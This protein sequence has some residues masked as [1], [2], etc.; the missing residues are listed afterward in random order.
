MGEIVIRFDRF[1]LERMIYI[2]IILVLAILL[3]F[4]YLS[5]SPT[6]NVVQEEDNNQSN[7]IVE[8]QNETEPEAAAE[9]ESVV[10]ATCSDDIKNQDETDVDCGGVCASI[11][12]EYFYDGECHMN[13]EPEEPELSGEFELEITDVETEKSETSDAYKISEFTA[14]V[15]NGM[16]ND[17]FLSIRA[18][19]KTLSG[20]TLLQYGV[21]YDDE[22]KP[23]IGPFDLG[24]VESGETITYRTPDGGNLITDAE[25][26]YDNGDDVRLVVELLDA[27]GN[28][29]ES[30][31][32]TVRE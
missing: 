13:P 27:N 5:D 7:Q 23:Y 24:E 4:S 31:T 15:H 10:D 26:S 8:E 25:G 16:S 14:E 2:I 29:E 21:E 18:F 30:F 20:R 9:T 28:I 11:N 22:E 12:G 32:R 6:S 1:I 17:E 19:V 3:V